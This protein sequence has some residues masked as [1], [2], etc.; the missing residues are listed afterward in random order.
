MLLVTF[1]LLAFTPVAA[2][3]GLRHITVGVSITGLGI[4][5]VIVVVMDR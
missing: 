1:I 2:A 4:N 3:W 5:S